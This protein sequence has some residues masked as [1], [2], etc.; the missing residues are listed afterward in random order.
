MDNNLESTTAQTASA[1][2][3]PGGPPSA[4]LASGGPPATRDLKFQRLPVSRI[5]P[6]R[7][8]LRR[9]FSEESLD[10][11]SKAIEQE[12]QLEPI[13]VRPVSGDPAADYEIVFGERRWRT[14]QRKGWS[15]IDAMVIE[16][17]SEGEAF[18]KGLMENLSR[19]DLNP[20][21][22]AAG[23][24]GLNRLDPSYWTHQKIAEA[25]GKARTYV[26][27]AINLLGLPEEVKENV[28]RATLSRSH[29]E[30][31]LRL[32]NPEQQIDM[33]RRMINQDWNVRK[34]EIEVNKALN[35]VGKPAQEGGGPEKA[36]QPA[37]LGGPS[38]AAAH[39]ASPIADPLGWLWGNLG[40][41][42]IPCD[43]PSLPQVGYE[44]E[45][46]WTFRIPAKA[47]DEATGE[48]GQLTLGPI[49]A[50]SRWFEKT[51]DALKG[52]GQ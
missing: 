14:F 48:P 17:P 19:E 35:K 45:G 30:L 33:A 25:F 29:A 27:E 10:T 34:A 40:F 50:L 36:P 12:G 42:A 52:M 49:A 11:L 4:S 43:N 46:V 20:I 38:P 24:D 47:M 37:D 32:P 44:A 13:L 15:E 41:A 39:P 5:R 18:A 1:S 8:Q 26:T 9:Q 16:N 2:L 6:S 23:Y 51:A 31:L 7:H 22:E 28:A 3:A 21:E